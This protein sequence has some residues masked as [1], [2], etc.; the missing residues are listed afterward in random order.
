MLGFLGLD[1]NKDKDDTEDF[2][3]AMDCEDEAVLLL[4]LFEEVE[5]LEL[6]EQVGAVPE[7]ARFLQLTSAWRSQ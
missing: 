4:L 5:D 2:D 6:S 1:K 3:C 7:A